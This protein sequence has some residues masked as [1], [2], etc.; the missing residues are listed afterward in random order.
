MPPPAA[1]SFP[2]LY[3]RASL[4]V[5]ASLCDLHS[6]CSHGVLLCVCFLL[7]LISSMLP[8]CVQLAAAEQGAQAAAE[9]L[10]AA[11]AGVEAAQCELAGAEAGDGRDHTNRSLK[12][13][14]GR[15]GQRSVS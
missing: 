4:P 9:A 2:V 7:C 5:N 12:V 14:R 11:Q 15:V 10:T 8:V 6:S 3:V 1:Q 13:G